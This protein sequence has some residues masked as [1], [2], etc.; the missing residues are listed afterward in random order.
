MVITSFPPTNLADS[1]GIL[2]VGGD[3]DCS[4]L[5]LAYKRGVFPWPIGDEG[6]LAWFAPP[7]RAVLFL[8]E[9]HIP[10]TLKKKLRKN[11]FTTK[12]N[13]DFKSVISCCSQLFNRGAQRGTWITPE[14]VSAYI[15][16]HQAGFCHS[17]ETYRD[18]KLVGGLYG[19][20]INRMFAGES[21]FY[22]EQ[23]A[24]KIALFF[25]IEDL[26]SDG[27]TWIDCQ[28]L[29]PFFESLGA[30]EITREAF[31]KLLRHAL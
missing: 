23:D 3:L 18:Q 25:L 17:Y 19:V 13:T 29:T 1:H 8:D 11:I 30:R 14:M 24:S 5:L 28:V 21:M 6:S 20:Q 9:L 27:V 15:K 31:E 7:Q 10:R 26:L 16:L 22:L 2:A 4:S 12:K